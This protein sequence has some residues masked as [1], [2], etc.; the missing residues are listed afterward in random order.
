MA[1]IVLGV[2]MLAVSFAGVFALGVEFER[3]RSSGL[4]LRG[5]AAR[6]MTDYLDNAEPD[7]L[8]VERA[9]RDAEIVAQM[10]PLSELRSPKKETQGNG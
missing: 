7:P 3:R 4:V 2:V 8:K 1:E 6:W 10:K 5:K 9:K